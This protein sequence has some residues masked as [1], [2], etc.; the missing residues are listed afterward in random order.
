L[1]T[2]VQGTGP[3]GPAVEIT[4]TVQ[5]KEQAKGGYKQFL[6]ITDDV[7]ASTGFDRVGSWKIRP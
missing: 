2:T 7:G 1:G 4:W 3:L 5:F 6:K